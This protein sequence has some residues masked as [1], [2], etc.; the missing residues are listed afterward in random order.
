MDTYQC[1]WWTRFDTTSSKERFRGDLW[2]KAGQD[3]CLLAPF[4]TL[5]PLTTSWDFGIQVLCM[6]CAMI[7]KAM[8]YLWREPQPSPNKDLGKCTRQDYETQPCT[9][10]SLCPSYSTVLAMSGH[11]ILLA[12]YSMVLFSTS[13]RSSFRSSR[14]T[15]LFL[16]FAY[17]ILQFYI[18]PIKNNIRENGN[19]N[20][21]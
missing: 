3:S 20:E 19:T 2:L 16:E 14:I 9:C 15:S 5:D 18:W 6:T 21:K 10:R 8:M 12:L 17:L 7:K 4:T 13:D 11:R 1:L